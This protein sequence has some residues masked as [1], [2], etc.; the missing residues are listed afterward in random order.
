MHQSS[1]DDPLVHDI[2]TKAGELSRRHRGDQPP[3][4]TGVTAGYDPD[5]GTWHVEIHTPGQAAEIVRI[6]FPATADQ[7][8]ARSLA[9]QIAE[10]RGLPHLED[11]RGLHPAETVLEQIR[12]VAWMPGEDDPALV[13]EVARLRERDD[14]A[15][16]LGLNRPT[17]PPRVVSQYSA[18]GETS[19]IVYNAAGLTVIASSD[20]QARLSVDLQNRPPGYTVQTSTN[21]GQVVQISSDPAT[22]RHL[23]LTLIAAAY[24]AEK[25]AAA[26]VQ[27]PHV[28]PADREG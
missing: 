18:N 9:E 26:L 12:T 6:A 3:A 17:Q 25:N 22:M 27:A 13:A 15:D 14:D 4:A 8:A 19:H 21:D 7:E 10:H 5:S 1:P 16:K 2:L 20:G 24:A 23:G 11:N 28:E